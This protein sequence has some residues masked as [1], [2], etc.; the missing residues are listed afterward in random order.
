MPK[1]KYNFTLTDVE[2]AVRPGRTTRVATL[3][4]T[5][6]ATLDATYYATDYA[7]YAATL[8]ATREAT[9]A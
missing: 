1:R 7:T 6:C 8:A 5:Y 4:A 3:D 2:A 9:N